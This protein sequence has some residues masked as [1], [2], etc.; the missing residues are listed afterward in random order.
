MRVTPRTQEEIDLENL[1]P[2]G[3]YD[4]EVVKAEDKISKKGKEEGLTEPNMIEL[5]LKVFHGDGYSFVRDW[6]LEAMP[7]KLLHFV[8]EAGLNDKYADGEFSAADC[9]GKC[10]KVKIVV[11]EAKGGYDAKNSVKDYGEKKKADVSAK[12]PLMNAGP[13]APVDDDSDPE[14]R[15]P[16]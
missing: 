15:I 5:N 11:E 16:F 10:G 8:N 9:H 13:K 14:N 2:A 7:G 4:F 12:G 3:V 6:L 1:I